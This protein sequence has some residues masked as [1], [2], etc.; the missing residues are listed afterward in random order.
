[1]PPVASISESGSD[2]PLVSP[3]RPD[4]CRRKKSKRRPAAAGSGL[5]SAAA[6]AAALRSPSEC[7][8]HRVMRQNALFLLELA[9]EEPPPAAG[10]SVAGAG[11]G[12]FPA[13][14]LQCLHT[15][16]GQQ[17]HLRRL[18]EDELSAEL[19]RQNDAE[20]AGPG[21]GRGRLTRRSAARPVSACVSNTA[22]GRFMTRQCA[23]NCS[24]YA[25][26]LG[27]SCSDLLWCV[28]CW[29]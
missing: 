12:P 13:V 22:T 21:A 29:V 14:A 23:Y 27:V 17:A 20:K 7:E 19:R 4:V 9:A 18:K 6:A 24:R 28:V 1:M 16:G 8:T 15:L 11:T 3:L 2:H 25:V 5:G 10:G 26:E